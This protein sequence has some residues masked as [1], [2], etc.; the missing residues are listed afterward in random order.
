ME[1]GHNS[2]YSQLWN[3][4]LYP[5]VYEGNSSKLLLNSFSALI[6]V[7]YALIIFLAEPFQKLC[8]CLEK[9]TVHAWNSFVFNKMFWQLRN[10]YF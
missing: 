3:R 7:I 5:F 6:A 2:L 9:E 10:I 8:L 4:R 1:K